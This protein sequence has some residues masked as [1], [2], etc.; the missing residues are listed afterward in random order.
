MDFNEP[1]NDDIIKKQKDHVYCFID[2]SVYY[3]ESEP[4]SRI[5]GYGHMIAMKF[6]FRLF[7]AT[8]LQPLRRKK[9]FRT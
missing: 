5:Y 9:F 2:C 4:E 1:W 3:K 7:E 8:Y 6:F